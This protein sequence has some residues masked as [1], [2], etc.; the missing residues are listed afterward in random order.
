MSGM[1]ALDRVPQQRIGEL[2][3][4]QIGTLRERF[5]AEPES[6]DLSA[7]RPVIA[8]SW[9]RS[10]AWSV[11]AAASFAHVH[12]PR[13]DEQ[14][15]LAAE[16]V[17]TELERLCIDT[18]GS[19]VLTDAEGTLAVFRG[20]A[21]ERQKAE[22]LFPTL[23]A[24][25]GEDVIGTNSDGTVLEEG[26]A[27][28]VWG[29]E[30]FNQALQQSYC[31]SVPV[32]DP[33]RRSIRG[34]LG[35]MLP[36]RVARDVDPRSVLMTVNGAAA[37]ITRRLGERL[38]ARE[39][40]LMSE[41]L[42]EARKRGADAV[43]AMD[44]RTTIASR[45]ALS[46]LH[47][48]DFAVLGAL[49]REAEDGGSATQRRVSISEGR[50][51]ML[52]IRPMEDEGGAA[53]M[54]VQ[55]PQRRR[56]PLPISLAPTEDGPFASILGTSRAMRRALD[57]ATS[58]ASR[59]MPAYIVGERGT[60][61]Q[62]LARAIASQLS[63][64][65]VVFD[66]G[67]TTADDETVERIDAA[68]ARGAAVVLHRLE[69][70]DVQMKEGLT[71]LLRILEQPQLVLTAISLSDDVLQVLAELRGI[72]VTMPPLRERR[73]D[74]PALAARFVADVHG[75]GARLSSKLRDALVNG[76]WP[77][78]VQQLRSLI[79]SLTATGGEL[80][81]SD[82]PQAQLQALS[83]TRLTRLEEAELQQIRAALAEARGSRV[84]AAQLLGI[85]RSTLY[86][87]IEAYEGRG[88][89]LELE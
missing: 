65:T 81:L 49:A 22:R 9:R 51:I 80:R 82:L 37:D 7:L 33:M 47:Q 87:K 20:D 16:P 50:E 24:A 40:A 67:R 60:G 12:D 63:S 25:M 8:R 85:G 21:H 17:L 72:E 3:N 84:A 74:I 10:L 86:R 2:S 28:Q 69:R 48:S 23:G 44:E 55:V 59:R 43:I 56:A 64:D 11:N 30:H 61:K 53:I 14:L 78:N 6:T 34:V 29:A 76:D 68:L 38:A 36:E 32:R 18:G 77:G 1:D 35:V 62:M 75:E 70:C 45:S 13:V 89:E 54:R 41:Y 79:E 58:A 39:Q 26:G 5:L 88:F 46:M 19:V 27:V 42:R 15:L 71:A 66:F 31:T 52:Q 73:E 4:V 57:A 83:T